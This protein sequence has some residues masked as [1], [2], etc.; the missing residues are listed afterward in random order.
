MKQ[1]FTIS[2]DKGRAA[3]LRVTEVPNVQHVAVLDAMG[4]QMAELGP[5]PGFEPA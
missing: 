3:L 2:P 5:A 1:S 4:D